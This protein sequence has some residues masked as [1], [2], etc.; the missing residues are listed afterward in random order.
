MTKEDPDFKTNSGGW[1]SSA[2]NASAH[3]VLKGERRAICSTISWAWGKVKTQK[4]CKT[5]EKLTSERA[6]LPNVT[7]VG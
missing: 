5:C 1:W 3:Y 4:K 2:P 6:D 7:T